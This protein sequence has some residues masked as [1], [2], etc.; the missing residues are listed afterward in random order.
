MPTRSKS[1]KAAV[2][3]RGPGALAPM[4]DMLRLFYRPVTLA[5]AA[6]VLAGGV[7][8][9]RLKGLFPELEQRSEYRLAASRIEITAPPH[10]V[11]HDLVEQVVECANLPKDLS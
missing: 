8:L 6:A 5:A 11:P 3:K 7:F 1:D 9:P 10:W 4:L 2:G